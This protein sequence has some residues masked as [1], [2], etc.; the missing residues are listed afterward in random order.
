MITFNEESLR[1][2]LYHMC[3][4]VLDAYGEMMPDEEDMRVIE[5]LVAHEMRCLIRAVE[6]KGTL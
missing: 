6:K 2:F 5:E 4:M 3:G 1:Y